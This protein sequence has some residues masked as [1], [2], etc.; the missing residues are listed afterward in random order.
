MSF[1]WLLPMITAAAVGSVHCV[2]MCGAL[3]AVASDGSRGARQRFGVLAGYQ[4][5]RLLS[6][7]LLGT[8]AGSLGHALDLAGKYAGFGEAAAVVAGSIMLLGGLLS[9][10]QALG[11]TALPR[12]PKLRLLPARATAWLGRAQQK[13]PLV[14]AVLLGGASALLPC[15][16]LYA[17]ALA[18]AATGS[19]LGGA[20]VMGALWLGSAPALLGFGMVVGSVLS[21]V[22]RHVPLLSAASVFALGVLT[23][24]LR[25]NLPAF[26]LAAVT[27]PATSAAASTAAPPP[28]AE[29]C[30]FH[31]HRKP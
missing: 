24:N 29:D 19:P 4:G 22:K 16:F 1:A 7:V 27:R 10:L 18:G 26:A 17:F 2:G 15:G 9:M 6:Y 14:R 25:I 31:R 13:P 20:L 3:V 30:P 21:R 8:A 5:A 11:R 23:L 28:S 12:L